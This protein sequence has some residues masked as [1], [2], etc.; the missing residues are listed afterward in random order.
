M[1]SP[2]TPPIP[3]YQLCVCVCVCV[4]VR[5]S[6]CVCV[7]VC[8]CVGV[9]CVCVCVCACVEMYITS[10]NYVYNSQNYVKK[11]YRK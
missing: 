9:C 10:Q 1:E 11:T 8:A 2:R 4:C 7:R 5:V 3:T 6:V